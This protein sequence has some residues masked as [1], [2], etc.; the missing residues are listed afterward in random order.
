LRIF[1]TG[2]QQNTIV[3][4]DMFELGEEEIKHK[5]LVEGN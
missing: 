1:T 3:L 5:S 4:G 2:I